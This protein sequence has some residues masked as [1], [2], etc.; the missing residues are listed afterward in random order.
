MMVAWLA[1]VN[2]IFAF[3]SWNRTLRTPTAVESSIINGTMLGQI[4][5]LA[6]L[7]S[8]ERLRWPPGLGFSVAPRGSRIV[9][10]RPRQLRGTAGNEG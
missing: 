4:V 9:Q 7:F 5:R 10:L 8:S 1:V 3:T 6:W 2:T